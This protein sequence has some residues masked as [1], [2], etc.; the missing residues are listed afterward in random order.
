MATMFVL[1]HAIAP[2]FES[3][4][5]NRRLSM[6]FYSQC[7]A[8]TDGIESLWSPMSHLGV[9]VRCQC[10]VVAAA[11][12]MNYNNRQAADRKWK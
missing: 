12:E 6:L 5:S 2:M 11:A 4:L 7:C 10:V 9:L 1:L 8:E 3:A